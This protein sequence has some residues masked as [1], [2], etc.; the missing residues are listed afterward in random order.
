MASQEQEGRAETK[1]VGSNPQDCVSLVTTWPPPLTGW[2]TRRTSSTV[3]TIQVPCTDAL[4][5]QPSRTITQ[6]SL[7]STTPISSPTQTGHNEH[8]QTFLPEFLG[9]V[10]DI[11][12]LLAIVGF[13]KC[14]INRRNDNAV[15]R[16]GLRLLASD[17]NNP[18][19][20]NAQGNNPPAN[21]PPANNTPANNPAG[22]GPAG[23]G[24]P[25]NGPPGNGPPGNNTPGNDPGANNPD[26]T[27]DI[28]WQNMVPTPDGSPR[29]DVANS[30]SVSDYSSGD[31]PDIGSPSSS[32]T[33][34]SGMGVPN[35]GEPPIVLRPS[36][37]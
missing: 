4:G 9:P 12:C 21:N 8:D 37:R 6:A 35:G 23:N 33:F 30:G 25:G 20:N 10:G 27:T 36:R 2:D 16:R 34:S 32:G 17:A 7:S 28:P 22:N 13:W 26:H 19:G 1:R 11:I 5:F 29:S 14:W 15:L 3:Y 24:P 31:T 18:P